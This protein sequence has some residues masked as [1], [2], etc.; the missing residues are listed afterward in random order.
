[1]QAGGLGWFVRDLLHQ[2]L[3]RRATPGAGYGAA[4]RTGAAGQ[5]SEVG[6]VSKV[7]VGKIAA[8]TPVTATCAIAA[9]LSALPRGAALLTFVMAGLV[10]AIHVFLADMKARRG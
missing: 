5:T 1:V 3:L 7:K 8:I 4:N 9:A 2:P 6:Q 10:P